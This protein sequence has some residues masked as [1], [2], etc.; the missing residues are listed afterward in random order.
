MNILPSLKSIKTV[1]FFVLMCSLSSVGQAA[2]KPITVTDLAGR[3]V[4]F[5]EQ[6]ERIILGDSRYVHALSI[7]NQ[8]DPIKP[9]AAMLSKLQWVDYGSYIAYQKRFPSIAD[10]P[11]IGRSSADSFSIESAIAL[12]ADLAIFSLDGHGPNARHSNIIKVLEKA[13]IKVVFVDFRKDPLKNTPKSLLLLGKI[14]GKEKPAKDFITFYQSQLSKVTNKIATLSQDEKKRVFIHSR[15]GVAN[16]CCETM[17][18][19]MMAD[20]IDAAG[21]NNIALPLI[22]G[23]AGMVN[24]EYLLTQQPDVYIA[25]AVGSKGMPKESPDDELPYVMLGA[26]VPDDF[27]QASLQ[28]AFERYK[29]TSLD[30]YQNQQAY[31]LWHGFYNSPLNLLA[32]QVVAK[33]LYPEEFKELNPNATINEFFQR[34]QAIPLTG[35][36]WTQL[37][38]DTNE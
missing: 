25:T 6:P 19:G 10:I 38:K 5:S 23:A 1:L 11:V 32:V 2:Q 20:F 12:N 34:F 15:V 18:R 33:W 13:G 27:A 17:V 4:T 37:A 14:L 35:V 7:L 31:A 30:A 28:Q 8:D 9:V 29:L 22:P 16:G 3:S 26:G 36:Y 24:H 21:G